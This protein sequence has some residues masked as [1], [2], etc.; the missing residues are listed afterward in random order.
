VD[1]FVRHFNIHS[2]RRTLIIDGEEQEAQYGCCT[3]QTRHIIKNVV[4]V[5]LAPANKNKRANKCTSYWFYTTILV[6][7]KIRKMKR[8]QVLALPL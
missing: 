3:F 5:E 4:P 8:S 7:D 1:T 6:V 2:S